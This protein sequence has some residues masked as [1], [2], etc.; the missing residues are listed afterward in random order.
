MVKKNITFKSI[1]TSNKNCSTEI[2]KVKKKVKKK[3]IKPDLPNININININKITKNL[4]KLVVNEQSVNEQ[5]VNELAINKIT[6]NEHLNSDIP[7]NNLSG[8]MCI[9]PVLLG[10]VE[11]NKF[12]TSSFQYGTN[13]TSIILYQNRK[14]NIIKS[15]EITNESIIEH[16]PEIKVDNIMNISK[17]KLDNGLGMNIIYLKYYIPSIKNDIHNSTEKYMWVNHIDMFDISQINYK[18]TLYKNIYDAFLRNEPLQQLYNKIPSNKN[19]D[20]YIYLKDIYYQLY[21]KN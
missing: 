9:I 20:D 10:S 16:F 15:N 17:T 12:K 19:D 6:L 13:I 5:S 7:S 11:L 21:N 1:I 14:I 2:K 8:L 18:N 3:V 4:E